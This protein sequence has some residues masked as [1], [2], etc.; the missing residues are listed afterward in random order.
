MNRTEC[1]LDA[2]VHLE[3]RGPPAVVDANGKELAAF[4]TKLWQAQVIGAV[5]PLGQG[6][7]IARM[8]VGF[9]RGPV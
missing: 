1:R 2:I 3:M 7:A 9:R 8:E 6:K 5:A 4:K